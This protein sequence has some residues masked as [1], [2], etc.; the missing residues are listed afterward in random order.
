MKRFLIMLLLLLLVLVGGLAAGLFLAPQRV[1]QIWDSLSLPG[2]AFEWLASRTT[3]DRADEGVPGDRA[4]SVV[5]VSG[6]LEAEQTAIVAEVGGQVI[7]V[8][9]AEGQAVT[10]GQPLVQ[11]DDSLL[12]AQLQQAEQAVVSTQVALHLAQAGPRPAEVAAA[13]AQ[14]Q[15]AQADLDGARQALADA[16][17]ARDDPQELLARI[18]AAQGRAALAQRQIEVQAA[19]EAVIRVLR[20][21]I[22]NDGSDQG[23]TQRAIYDQQQAAAVEN[24]AAAQAELQGAQRVLNALRQMRANPASADAQLRAAESQV[25][26]AEQAL[27][28]AQAGLALAAAGPQPEAVALAATQV[29]EAEAARDALA[30]PLARMMLAS[31]SDGVILLRAVEP[32]ETISPATPLLRVADLSQLTLT[33]YVPLERI[34]R[35]QVGQPAQ[36]SVDAYPD[37][38]FAGAVTA[39]ASQAEFTPKNI[40]AAGERSEAVF[41]VTITLLGDNPDR[42]LKPGMLA[43]VEISAP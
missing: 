14:V 17:A 19:R 36:I 35:V 3:A 34:G 27:A 42:A 39:I 12:R 10:A 15:Q 38:A 30:A 1:Q 22:A 23:Q 43:D 8:L 16:Q 6:F 7:E 2:Q 4:A 5:S 32:G 33:V 24:S 37:R 40:L 21:S 13:Q 41:A 25:R 9:A 29:A 31:P 28:V 18:N 26:L 11:L 20:E